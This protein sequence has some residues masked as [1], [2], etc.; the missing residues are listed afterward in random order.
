LPELSQVSV[1]AGLDLEL[2]A[3]NHFARSAIRIFN[4]RQSKSQESS[5]SLCVDT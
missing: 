4:R 1:A 5:V 3:E 2:L